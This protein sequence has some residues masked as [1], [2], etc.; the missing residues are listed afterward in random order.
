MFQEFGMRTG[1]HETEVERLMSCRSRDKI[2]SAL[3]LF[4]NSQL[5]PS[6]L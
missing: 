2:R 6:L 3:T 4:K 1:N 5:Y